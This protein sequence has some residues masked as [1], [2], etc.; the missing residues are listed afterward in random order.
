MK[1]QDLLQQ[2]FGNEIN[3]SVDNNVLLGDATFDN[4]QFSICGI[5]DAAQLDNVMSLKL[6]KF[7]LDKVNLDPKFN[8]LIFI[9]TGGQKT[10]RQAELL[11]LNRYFA[12]LIKVIHYARAKGARVFSLVY[13]SALGGAFIAAGLN[14]EKVYALAEAQIAVMWL[15]AMSRVTKI[16]L[17]RLEELSKSSAIFAP[18]A[19]NFVK[20]GVIDKIIDPAA[21]LPQIISD[22][23]DAAP[24][25]NHWREL[26]DVRGGRTLANKI[27]S[28]VINA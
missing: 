8:L 11:G 3:Y 9:D 26:A 20:L 15:E 28:Q 22:I 10:S 14:A 27:V 7:I 2:L 18:G 5:V 6:A 24:L 25:I 19:E 21:F 16:P 23:G 1:Y 4:L 12:H 17:A 13:G